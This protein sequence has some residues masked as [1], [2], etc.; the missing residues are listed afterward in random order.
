MIGD[1]IP[2]TLPPA[3]IT[4]RLLLPGWIRSLQI[5]QR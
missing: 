1:F 4:I 5:H 2:E 3:D